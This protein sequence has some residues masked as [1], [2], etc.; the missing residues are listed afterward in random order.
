MSDD[1]KSPED[2]F[3]EPGAIPAGVLPG[4]PNP[5]WAQ[6]TA[7]NV[8][9][10]SDDESMTVNAVYEHEFFNAGYTYQGPTLCEECKHGWSLRKLAE[11]K[12]LDAN[13]LPFLAREEFCTVI[14]HTLFSL[15][16]RRVTECNKFEPGGRP[17][18]KKELSNEPTD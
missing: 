5:E 13:G 8:V 12:N 7:P 4:D 1:K 9:A 15:D 2:V 11:V 6:P 16:D 18:T 17:R 10:E 14:D 3:P